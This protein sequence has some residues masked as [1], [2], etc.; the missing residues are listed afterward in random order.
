MI[1]EKCTLSPYHRYQIGSIIHL[2]LL[3]VGPCF[4]FAYQPI[5]TH[6]HN[7]QKYGIFFFISSILLH[8][9]RVCRLF[10]YSKYISTRKY[11]F[12]GSKFA[13]NSKMKHNG[14][15]TIISVFFSIRL[16]LKFLLSLVRLQPYP[17]VCCIEILSTI[18]L[19]L[20]PILVRSAVD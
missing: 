9:C 1:F 13:L 17:F 2:L 12:G 4:V 18:L 19:F 20:L 16:W 7:R 14:S 3:R 6:I 8:F 15:K 11:Y 10:L 5:S